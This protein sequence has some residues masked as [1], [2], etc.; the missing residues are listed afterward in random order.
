[1]TPKVS[2][3]INELNANLRRY[4]EASGKDCAE[5]VKDEA[6]LF[7][8]AL[9]RATPPFGNHTFTQ[10]G[11]NSESWNDQRKIGE[12]AVVRDMG[13]AFQEFNKLAI[14]AKPENPKLAEQLQKYSRRG[15]ADKIEEVLG[16]LH[17]RNKV[18]VQATAEMHDNQRTKRGRVAKGTIRTIIL[19]AQTLARLLKS[20]LADV[21]KAKAGWLLAANALGAKGI[22]NWIRRHA[23]ATAGLFEDNTGNKSAPSITMGN[24]IEYAEQFPSEPFEAAT[25]YRKNQIE[26]KIERVIAAS[27]RKH[28]AKVR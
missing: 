26:K 24:L 21:G 2:I 20:R 4:I 23:G 25:E 19:R 22:P 15:M 13:R 6:R 18:E 12:G 27:A 8:V 3:N 14:I 28:G 17:F 11:E 1:M 16:K 9:M 7:V 5:A 10:R